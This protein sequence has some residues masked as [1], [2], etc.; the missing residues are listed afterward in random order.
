[1]EWLAQAIA[2][3]GGFKIGVALI[4]LI[5]YFETKEK[6]ILWWSI[7]WFFFFLHNILELILIE[8]NGDIFH[9]FAYCVYAFTAV[10]FLISIEKMKKET[11]P[12]FSIFG[13]RFSIWSLMAILLSFLAVVTSFYGVY[14]VREWFWGA[15]PSSFINGGG[16]LISAYFIYRLEKYKKSVSTLLIFYG[17]LLNGLHNLDYPFLRP[18]TWFAPIGFGLGV[19]FSLIFAAGFIV[20]STEELKKQREKSKKIAQDLS[21]LNAVSSA[22]LQSLDLDRILNETLDETLKVLGTDKGGIYLVDE[23]KNELVFSSH[24]G[25]SSEFIRGVESLKL[26]EGFAGYVVKSNEPYFV[27]DVS[28]EKRS[29]SSLIEKEGFQSFASVPLESGGKILGVLNIVYHGY[30]KFTIREKNLLLAIANQ[31]GIAIKNAKLFKQ[32]KQREEDLSYIYEASRIFS[33]TLEFK[34]VLNN[35]VRRSVRAF[36]VDSCL[37]RL[38]ELDKLMVKASFSRNKKDRKELESLLIENPIQIGKGIAGKVAQTGQPSIS[39]GTPVEKLTLPGYVKYLEKRHW[40]VVPMNVKNETI[41]VLTLITSN[42]T[43][44]FSE[45]D[46]SLA[47]GIANQ[48]A[49][50][51]KNARLYEEIKVAYKHLQD[52]Q[53]QVIQSEKIRALGE[54]A[55]GVAHDFNN[56]LAA[57]LGRTQLLLENTSEGESRKWLKVIEQASLDGA[58]IV[59][60]ILEFS[61]TY[62]DETFIKLELN[63]LVEDAIEIT[64]PYWKD[65][66]EV[67]GIKINLNKE[68]GMILPIEGNAAELREVIT[69]LIINAVDAMPEGGILN[70]KTEVKESLVFLSV[71]DTGSGM[72]EETSINIFE[73]FFTTK[74]VG[75]TGLGLSTCNG[76]IKRHQ[77]DIIVNSK[78]G[79]GTEIIVK[80]PVSMRP[81]NK[82]QSSKVRIPF[83]PAKILI[84]DDDKEVR[85]VLGDILSIAGYDINSFPTGKEGLLS[86]SE[87]DYDLVFTDLGMPDMTG[88]EIANSIN[89]INSKIPVILITGWGDQFGREQLKESGI[90][91][92]ISKPFDREDLLKIVKQSLKSR[93]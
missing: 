33:S 7:G 16:F 11:H 71:K 86:F 78:E 62:R 55:G 12:L 56:L 53:N 38:V 17:F 25:F 42:M 63:R 31:V 2:V 80:I 54:M 6:A 4:L 76:I 29:T 44:I 41:G 36:N 91:L 79:E 15:F 22:V 75:H 85:N 20:R 26:G 46:I 64:R 93:K 59:R 51:I 82:K 74:G 48:A 57:I 8:T 47:Q 50:A 87:T 69:N 58:E 90:D 60:K 68:L 28:K 65:K 1:M 23:Q 3:D 83:K 39:D 14:V 9:F 18:V 43:R 40:L 45:R 81:E 19:V 30:H 52:F 5:K 89:K 88:W 32:S 77:G 72:K 10:A 73:P 84:I 66:S 35:I 67:R 21:V 13:L 27:E 61:K 34:E 24:R 92:I 70:L 37:L 49:I